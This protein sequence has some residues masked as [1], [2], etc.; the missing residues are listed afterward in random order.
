[1]QTWLPISLIHSYSKVSALLKSASVLLLGLKAMDAPQSLPKSVW[2]FLSPQG[3]VPSQLSKGPVKIT[4]DEE[5][6]PGKQRQLS[7]LIHGGFGGH[8]QAQAAGAED[9]GLET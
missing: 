9:V 8:H 5:P 6:N 3:S 1:M 7:A 4:S 2:A